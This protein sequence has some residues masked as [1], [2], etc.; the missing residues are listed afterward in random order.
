MASALSAINKRPSSD[1]LRTRTHNIRIG[2]IDV[3]FS[4]TYTT[5]GEACDFGALD[6]NLFTHASIVGVHIDNSNAPDFFFSWD[7]A[8]K[9][10]KAFTGGA[11]V[12]N[13]NGGLAGK[14]ISCF[15]FI[16]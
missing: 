8:N 16:K 7:R 14:T 11:E 12:A 6:A 1:T 9:K 4:G 15:L 10:L 5:G 3:A 13:G 2:R